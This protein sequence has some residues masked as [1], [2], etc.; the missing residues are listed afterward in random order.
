MAKARLLLFDVGNTNTK[1][2]LAD[3]TGLLASYVLPTVQTDTADGLGLRIMELCGLEGVDPAEVETLAVCSV[4]PAMDPI[5]IGAGRRFFSRRV[6]F[7][8]GDLEIGL[9]NRYARPQ[10]VGADRLVTAFAARRIERAERIIVIDFGTATTFDCVLGEAYLGGLICPGVLSSAR[11][12][13]SGTAKLPQVTLEVDISDLHIGKSTSDSLNQGLVFG[14]A[15]MVDG[16]VPRL[17]RAMGGPARVLAT[18][19]LARRVAAAS[20]AV[21]EVREDLLLEGLRLACPG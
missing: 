1:I 20:R 7:A 12:L 3:G 6:L 21:H 14:F 15:A 10:E 16:L 8:P 19:G 17:E 5:L 9:E 4:V 2:G 11:A 18:G 13:A